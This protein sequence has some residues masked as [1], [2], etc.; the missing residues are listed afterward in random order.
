MA[1]LKPY[2][3]AENCAVVLDAYGAVF[4]LLVQYANDSYLS[5][6]AINYGGMYKWM[7]N[8]GTWTGGA[9]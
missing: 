8:N 9:F 5:I 6:L 2:I 3:P 1:N 7:Y 4:M